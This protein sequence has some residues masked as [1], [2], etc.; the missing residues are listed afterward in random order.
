MPSKKPAAINV[1]SADADSLIRHLQ[2]SLRLAQR[3]IALRPYR[4][5]DDLRR[6]WG[7]DEDT[8]Q[9][10]LPR[11]DFGEEAAPAS[12]A[13]AVPP[14]KPES[15]AR[16]EAGAPV[17][18]KTR[19][20]STPR[21]APD[22][23]EQASPS[24]PVRAKPLQEPSQ[25]LP[26]PI[27]EGAVP[28]EPAR[29]KVIHVSPRQR[30]RKPSPPPAGTEQAPE[31]ATIP[32]PLPKPRKVRAPRQPVNW[33]AVL[34]LGIILLVGAYLRFTGLNWDENRHQHP[35]ERF[36]T[37]TA[38]Q[39]R[40]VESLAAYFDTE[41]STLNPLKMGSYTY[42]ML[43]LFLA[44]SVAQVLD[45]THYDKV[46]LVGRA[47]SGLFDLAAI[48]LL[49][50]LGL[51][52]YS[53]KVGLLAAGL[54]AAAVLP[55]QL[56][57]YFA[58]DSFSTVFVVGAFLLAFKAVPIDR[59][60][61]RPTWSRLGWFLVF[62]LCVGA[63]M[64]CKVNT[65]PVFGLIGVGGAAYLVSVWKEP[66][67]RKRA[68][69][70]ILAGGVLAG[71][72]TALAFRV[73]QPYAFSGPGFFGLKL[74]PRWIR[75][76]SEVTNQV[77]GNSEWPPNHHWT[78][79][80]VTYAWMNMVLWGLGLPLGL[81]AWAG[82]GWSGWRIWKGDWRRHLLPFV[83]VGAYFLWQNVQFWRYMRYFIPIYPIIILLGA[84]ALVE[85]WE[86][87]RPQRILLAGLIRDKVFTLNHLKQVWAGALGAAV[88]VIVIAGTYLYAFVFNRI[89][90]E[91]ITRI[92]ASRWMLSNIPAPV[93][94]IASTDIGDV[95]YPIS[96]QLNQ[97]LSAGQSAKASFTATRTGQSGRISMPYPSLTAADIHFWLRKGVR[98]GDV[99]SEGHILLPREGHSGEQVIELGE[100]NLEA[101][102]IYNLRMIINS[103]G[104][105]TAGDASLVST[106]PEDPSLPFDISIQVGD[107]HLLDQ[108]VVLAPTANQR[109]NK[110]VI[111]DLQAEAV[112]G[113]T[114]VQV[115][116]TGD[117]EGFNVLGMSALTI[118]LDSGEN[119]GALEFGFPPVQLD[120]GATYYVSYE[121]ISG[122]PLSLRGALFALETSWDDALPLSVD[123]YDP[124][125][126]MY[127]PLNLELYVPDS[128]EKREKMISILDQVDYLVLPSNRA[129]DAM[130]RLP[131]RY[132]LTLRYYQALFNCVCTGDA[133]EARANSLEPPFTSPLGFD[134]VATFDHP[135]DF[136]LFQVSD[137]S[138][139][140]AFTV[141]DHPKVMVF[142]KS[143][144][145]SSEAVRSILE[146]ADLTEI[147]EQ[148]PL[149]YTKM[150]T[151]LRLTAGR[152][153]A[154]KAGGTWSK[155]FDRQ[156][157]LNQNEALGA[158]AWY[159][160]ILVI[161]WMAFP[162]L[163]AAFP[164]LK[165]RGYP[166]ARLAGLLFTAWLA[167]LAAS[168]KL[169]RF[170]NGLLLFCM[171]VLLFIGIYFARKKQA[172]LA[173]Y[174]RSR[175]TNL[176]GFE[177]LFLALFLAA[178]VVR[179]G[180]PDLWNPWLGGEKPMD[181]AFF[182]AVLKAVY[183]PP[184]HPWF[185]GNY[186]NYYYYGYVVA[187]V[188]TRLLGI[189]P[190]IAFNLILPTWFAFTGGGIFSAAYNII[191][192]RRSDEEGLSGDLPWMQK[193]RRRI[194]LGAAAA[195]GT[196]A[197]VLM[198]LI[199]NLYQVRQLVKYLPDAAAPP[200]DT[201]S[202]GGKISAVLSGAGRVI[203]GEVELPGDKGRW[204]F[205]PSRPI[206]HDGP[207]TP[208]AEFPLFTF[209]YGDLHAHLLTM[210]VIL[211]AL[212]WI[213]ARLL[214]PRQ[215][216]PWPEQIAF[217]LVGGIIIGMLRPAHTWDYPSLLGLAVAALVWDAW[218]ENPAWNK[219]NIIRI[220]ALPILLAV[221][222]SLLYMPFSHWF[223]TEYSSM[224]LWKGMR[225]PLGDY[226]TTHGVFLF[227]LISYLLALSREGIGGQWQA[228]RS[229]P[230]GGRPG[231]RVA[232]L[233]VLF[234][235]AA[236]MG[237]LWFADYQVLAF[238]IPLL[239]WL[240]AVLFRKGRS[241]D[242][243]ITLALFAA[244][245]GV[246]LV[247]EVIVLKGDVGRSNMV[248][249]YYNQAWCFFSLA[250]G[251]SL[252]R[253]FKRAGAWSL[254]GKAAWG[255]ALGLLVL[256]GALYTIT[257]VPLKMAD[258]WPGIANPPH[259]LDGTAFMLGESGQTL[260]TVTQ[261]AV[262]DD[263][264]RQ[265]NLA[266]DLA[267]I[268]YLQ[269]NAVGTPVIVEGQTVEYRWGS[270][271]SIYTGLPDV[272]GWSW[273]VRQHNSIL[274]SSLVE[275]RIRAVADFYNTPDSQAAVDFLQRY[276]VTYIIVGDLERGYYAAEGLDK[277]PQM[278]QAGLLAEAFSRSVA[279]SQI[280]IYQ[281][282]EP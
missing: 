207:D 124:L 22:R 232:W 131:L 251:V 242:E 243:I 79:R 179:L 241:L 59:A 205:G 32:L 113:Q 34:L 73:L 167:W 117:R 40:P 147:I 206:I 41:N 18:P 15:R 150:P 55:I 196:A 125:G 107:K 221:L 110:L 163:F 264:G 268:Q 253:L 31:A 96:I 155:L 45:M 37:M 260:D 168:L 173:A 162:T 159:L 281:V 27:T 212:G 166:L 142:K 261:P 269:D 252:A 275:N 30:V 13:A 11:V 54:A 8:L 226:L 75:V 239:A 200:V 39:I 72:G 271:Y 184:E 119:T 65:A 237:A 67:E 279:G 140:E 182:N 270:R 213:L 120:K 211:L 171:L 90:Q 244:G 58:V 151:G 82:W 280:T 157:A 265:I 93:N 64:A 81:A 109:V 208:I 76:I 276:H 121:L 19:L 133:M 98:G 161:G 185:S 135:L 218:K 223:G 228:L 53:R 25:P 33:R 134:L 149:T 103:S 191:A 193:P 74:N 85:V 66:Q 236:A 204:Y 29:P 92:E 6:V 60:V 111:N 138:A 231:R 215:K 84:W 44:R 28:A 259:K 254:A 69:F 272:V 141:Y 56:S 172:E 176:I 47:L 197:V 164:G 35:D 78:D 145:Y 209:L 177:G 7:L 267:G 68:F 210:P 101:G 248:F 246:T 234:V 46:V 250:S 100:T 189:L 178:L 132:P 99:I 144:A 263:E 247:V 256:G 17:K 48:V 186:I 235:A 219:G 126:G 83:W 20:K 49:Y 42:G 50:L 127:D 9:R 5:A 255:S 95:S 225:T 26:P 115:R 143:E 91:P 146:A 16:A 89:F 104:A 227:I 10:I 137:L 153:A 282:V 21:P 43:P 233:V 70:V 80:G 158:V 156:S 94:V 129:Y 97:A 130:P 238:G 245:V 187:A 105:V 154:Q 198:L 188:P 224:E 278:V 52:L 273:H 230:L 169:A 136:G 214:R 62:G 122:G 88:V 1:N 183:F 262:Y 229:Q 106:N 220:A 203:S 14:Q 201:S 128:V 12:A 174:L 108:V 77:A 71:L 4:S 181:F 3:L 222:T 87:T 216:T 277:F 116:L 190:S 139:D 199:G 102:E 23:P 152:L 257:A 61:E 217:W 123:G 63:A 2:I 175:R 240:A 114:T 57:H 148:G 192:S 165:D 170:T 202:L 24:R 195:A 194:N 118:D 274:P 249:R 258:R 86:R 160:L 51:R 180:N 112:S 38:E 266:S 36:I